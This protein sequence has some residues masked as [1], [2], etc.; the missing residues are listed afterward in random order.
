MN[1][2]GAKTNIGGFNFEALR[3]MSYQSTQ[4]AAIGECLRT[5]KD[6][7][8]NNFES[9]IKG[10]QV[11]AERN[12]AEAENYLKKGLNSCACYAFHRAANYY[13]MAEFYAQYTDPRQEALW[14]RSRE[15]FFQACKLN[16]TEIEPVEIPFDGARLPGYFVKSGTGKAPTLIAMS[17]FDG[18]AEELYHFIGAVAPENGWNCLM[19]E[20]PGQRGCLHLNPKLKL[21]S[22][23][24]VPVK[25][26]VDYVV[27][28]NEVDA[29]KMALIGYSLGGY[30]A[31]RAAAYEHRFKACIASSLVI[32]IGEAVRAVWP[33]VLRNMN[34]GV[35]NTFFK[36]FSIFN[37]DMK[38]FYD[39]AL[40]AM[41]INSPHEFISAFDKFSLQG[42]QNQFECPILSV[43]GAD[44]LEQTSQLLIDSTIK[45]AQTV[46]SQV[47][48]FS[49]A[50]GASAHCQIGNMGQSQALIFEWLNNTVLLNKKE[51]FPQIKD[52]SYD[53]KK[54]LIVNHKA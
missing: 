42:L 15:C 19:F 12:S 53:K 21:R 29:D 47:H 7:K 27:S 52:M 48:V 16:K 49:K 25:A 43:M 36:G 26:V 34:A 22:D 18:S 5:I 9:W 17:G 1:F 10:W 35:F 3:G 46:N 45:W 38:W 30:L 51:Y 44:E 8:Q 4:G 6:I 54:K 32:D 31:P 28:R 23:Y 40:W 33:E 13:R 39:Q 24:E 14:R 20:G 37:K 41:D 50:T 2:D 11:L